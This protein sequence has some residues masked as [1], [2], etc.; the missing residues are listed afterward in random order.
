M[1]SPEPI[2]SSGIQSEDRARETVLHE[3]NHCPETQSRDAGPKAADLWS[4]KEH[5][6]KEGIEVVTPPSAKE[7]RAAGSIILK[8]LNPR[9][10]IEPPPS[11][12]ITPR[13]TDLAGKKIGLYSNGKAGTSVFFDTL[14]RLL[15]ERFPT[16][17]LLRYTGAFDPG[18]KLAAKIAEECDTFIDG[19]GD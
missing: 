11:L 14:E 13:L 4:R 10:E 9:G 16:A 8:V 17:T 6:M 1:F 3:F 5:R 2:G 19:V 12:T 7:A 18:E 15:K